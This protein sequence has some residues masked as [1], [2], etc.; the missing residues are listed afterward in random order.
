MEKAIT[1]GGATRIL[2]FD[3]GAWEAAESQGIAL[4]ELLEQFGTGKKLSFK[5]VRI[6]VWAMLDGQDVT[7]E[8][9]RRWVTGQNFVAVVSAVGEVIRET[10]PK[11]AAPAGNPPAEPF[12]SPDSGNGSMPSGSAPGSIAV[13]DSVTA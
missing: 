8:Q 5:A 3:L 6:L 2:R 9:V 10:F 11:E 1:L 12:P 7:I 13:G 4:D